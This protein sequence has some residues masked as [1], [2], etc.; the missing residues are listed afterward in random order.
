MQCIQSYL[1]YI[2]FA[3]ECYGFPPYVHCL[4][5]T[6]F[7]SLTWNRNCVNKKNLHHER[8]RAWL[9]IAVYSKN[10]P[11]QYLK[12]FCHVSGWNGCIYLTIYYQY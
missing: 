9:I 11:S 8:I 3:F 4:K 2:L 7:Y 10:V 1:L 12:I 5:Y 6:T